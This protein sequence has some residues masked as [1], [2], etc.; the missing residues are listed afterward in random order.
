MK[1]IWKTLCLI[2]IIFQFSA[3]E[4]QWGSG[5]G[6]DGGSDSETDDTDIDSGTSDTTSYD[7]G[8]DG[9]GGWGDDGGG[10]WGDESGG[11]WGDESGGGNGI[12]DPEPYKFKVAKYERFAPPYDTNRELIFYTGVVEDY[13]CMECGTDSL[14]FRA[15][16]YLLSYFGKKEL[17]SFITEDKKLEKI[18]LLVRKPML[19]S[20]NKHSKVEMGILE[21]K[22]TLQFRD[23]RYKY[24]F[25]NFVHEET[26]PGNKNRTSR[27]YH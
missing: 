26:M 1:N 4:A 7:D 5:W 8:D 10:G 6:G 27:T 21:Y 3:A 24:Q 20:Y 14:Y 17:K 22:L 13:D 2:G 15:K 25:G 23:A 16:A 11:G 18:V 12:Q 19:I 9:D